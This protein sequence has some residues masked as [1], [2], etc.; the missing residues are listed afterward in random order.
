[1]LGHI[2]L[3]GIISPVCWGLRSLPKPAGG[4]AHMSIPS[5]TWA[6]NEPRV[7]TDS[8]P[9]SHHTSTGGFQVYLWGHSR[10]GAGSHP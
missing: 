1:M 3:A 7:Q 6:K 8:G 9:H 10:I 5:A 4:P 2:T